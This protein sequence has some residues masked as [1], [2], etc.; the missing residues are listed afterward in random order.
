MARC[1]VT[2]RFDVDLLDDLEALEL[3]QS[4]ASNDADNGS[5]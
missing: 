5:D 3:V 4:R 2:Y 1:L